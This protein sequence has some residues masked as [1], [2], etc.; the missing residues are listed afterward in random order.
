MIFDQERRNHLLQK[1]AVKIFIGGDDDLVT[2]DNSIIINCV[3]KLLRK[4]ATKQTMV[5]NE[6]T[7][8]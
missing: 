2:G 3:C 5:N 6:V 4:I 7:G 1:S 8:M